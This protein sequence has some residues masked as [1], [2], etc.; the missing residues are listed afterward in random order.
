M[1]KIFR[2]IS[3]RIL[4]CSL[5]LCSAIHLTAQKNDGIDTALIPFW[6]TTTMYNE[7]VLMISKDGELPVA[8]LLFKPDQILS[9]R[10]SA[11]NIDY[12]EGVDWECKNLQLSLL[13][14]SKAAF[15]TESQLYPDTSEN[16]FPKRGGA[17]SYTH[18]T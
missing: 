5:L 3:L 7:S 9:V 10:N 14:G 8:N 18:L 13:K 16:A 15:L 2:L 17:V 6:K 4:V 1:I 12:V 11:L